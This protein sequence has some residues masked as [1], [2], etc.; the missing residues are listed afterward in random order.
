MRTGDRPAARVGR[1]AVV[2]GLVGWLVAWAPVASAEVRLAIDPTRDLAQLARS[3]QVA[4]AFDR[5][6]GVYTVDASAVLP[7]SGAEL[8]RV[9]LDYER[10]A[11]IGVPNVREC[12]VVAVFPADDVVYAWAWMSTLGH[13]SKHYLRVRVRHDLPSAGAA[14]LEWTL[15]ARQAAWPYEHAPAFVR[16]EGSWYVEPLPGRGSYVRYFLRAVPDPALPDALV[17]WLIERQLRTGAR[18]VVEALGREAARP[19]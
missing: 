13:S 17:G 2:A 9:A 1:A 4:I 19:R 14:A 6:D 18:L 7:G 10:Y 5:R 11:S 3:G 15:A 8:L 12:H 16:L